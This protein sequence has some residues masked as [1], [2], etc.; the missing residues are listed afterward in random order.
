MQRYR[1]SNVLK[2]VRRVCMGIARQRSPCE[3]EIRVGWF[4]GDEGGKFSD[5]C[6]KCLRVLLVCRSYCPAFHEPLL[7]DCRGRSCRSW[8]ARQFRRIDN[9]SEMNVAH[10]TTRDGRFVS[11][12]NT[13]RVANR[14]ETIE[15]RSTTAQFG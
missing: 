10:V 12:G 14:G 9:R 13:L 5:R 4:Q 1:Y 6:R 3:M 7:S 11:C 2:N 15:R 8:F